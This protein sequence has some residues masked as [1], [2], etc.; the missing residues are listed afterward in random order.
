MGAGWTLKK[1]GEGSGGLVSATQGERGRG[2]K[3]EIRPYL[4]EVR[5]GLRGPGGQLAQEFPV[6]ENKPG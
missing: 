3:V 5:G 2:G 6:G 1:E 4:R